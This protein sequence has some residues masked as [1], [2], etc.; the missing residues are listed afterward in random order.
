VQELLEAASR[1][2]S[3]QA[4]GFSVTSTWGA[5][6][7]PDESSALGEAL[8]VADQRMYARKAGRGRSAGP[9]ARQPL[10]AVRSP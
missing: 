9:V 7:L 8:H 4:A 6:S 1:A 10:R 3:E 2:L 5:V